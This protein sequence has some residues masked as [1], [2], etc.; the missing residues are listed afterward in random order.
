[1]LMWQCQAMNCLAE[2]PTPVVNPSKPDGGSESGWRKVFR[3]AHLHSWPTASLSIHR[4][5]FDRE[6]KDILRAA[7]AFDYRLNYQG[8]GSV[9]FLRV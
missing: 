6:E 9:S 4:F 7:S 1:M 3:D 5:I 8:G 2:P